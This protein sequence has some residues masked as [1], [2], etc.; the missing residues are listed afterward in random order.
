MGR[1]DDDA[2]PPI[3]LLGTDLGVES[4][5]QVALGPRRSKPGRRRSLAVAFG[6]VAL[7]VGGVV[8]G[9]GDDSEGAGDE[10]RDNQERIDLDKPLTSTTARGSTTSRPTT[11]TA[12]PGPPLG[13][14]VEGAFLVYAG[15]WSRLDLTTGA[16]TPLRLPL[17]N[18]YDAV[19]VAGGI[20]VPSGGGEVW[21]IPVLGAGEEPGHVVLGPGDRVLRAGGDRMWLIHDPAPEG[22]P[23][24]HV[25]V[26]LVDLEGTVLRSFQV[27]GG[28]VADA[29]SDAVILSRAGRVYA[30]DED[31]IR[32][33]ATGAPVG[34]V[35]DAVLLVTCDD[36]A[37]CA[38]QRHSTDGRAPRELVSLADPDRVQYDAVEASDGRVTV[39]EYDTYGVGP[40]RFL[41]FDAS[42]AL[43]GAPEVDLG[44]SVLLSEILPENLG[45]LLFDGVQMQRLHEVG[46]SWTLEP[47]RTEL[48]TSIEGIV[49]VTP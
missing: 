38:L 25:D 21:F 1:G 49:V 31:G 35:G 24:L 30:A 15:T 42:G 3:E 32:P 10:E 6:V 45:F 48:P 4:K 13:E 7:L 20:A 17:P 33:I 11:T 44:G 14:P 23:S 22:Q 37:E 29:T 36:R 27:P 18:F 16:L 40:S 47:I 8:F 5:Q 46:G 26:R 34:T 19:A 39:V 28:D 9:D 41:L 2:R 43:L 12:P